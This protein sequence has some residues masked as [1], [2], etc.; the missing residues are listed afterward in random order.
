MKNIFSFFWETAKVIII[1]L[2]IVVPIRYF[3]FQPFF[4]KGQSMDPSFENGDYLIVDEISYLFL[5]PKRGEVIVFKYPKNPSQRYIK[6]II[7]LPGETIEVKNGQV[8]VSD[9]EGSRTLD[10]SDYLPLGTQTFKDI[11]IT[12][13]KD[14]YF[15]L[16][17]NR[18]ASSDSRS[19]GALGK[20]FI[21]GRVFVRAWPVAAFAKIEAPAY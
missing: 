12:L 3:V 8:I 6:R 21:V 11:Q 10:E 4:V 7:G 17:D 20:E 18:L 5:A 9:K 1:A 15:V 16:G 13:G 2:V 19:W 14:E